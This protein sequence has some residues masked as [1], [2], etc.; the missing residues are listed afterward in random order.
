MKSEGDV[1]DKVYFLIHF[2][3]GDNHKF[4]NIFLQQSR[5]WFLEL[6]IIWLI[7]AVCLLIR[8]EMPRHR[9][10]S[11]PERLSHSSSLSFLLEPLLLLKNICW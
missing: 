3:K 2:S 4:A 11:C 10:K 9:I 5:I 1:V 7:P 6:S 8:F